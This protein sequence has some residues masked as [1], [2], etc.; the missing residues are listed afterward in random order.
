MISTLS[1]KILHPSPYFLFAFLLIAL[2]LRINAARSPNIVHPD[3]I[4]QTLEPGHRLA[5]GYGVITWE[6]REGIRSWVL[7]AFLALVMRATAWMGTG[8]TGYVWGIAIVLSMMSLT[9]VWFGFSWANHTSGMEA[10]IIAAGACAMWYGLVFFGPS[11]LT[12]VV[13]THAL[14]PGLYFG[15]YG[16]SLQERRR[17][18]LAGLF[19]GLAVSLRIQLAPA[20]IFAVVYFCYSD[21][22]RRI[23]PATIGL[24][25]PVLAFGLIDALTWSYPFQSFFRNFWLNVAAGRS[26]H[27]GTQPW[28]WYLFVLTS[29]MFPLVVLALFGFRRSPLLGWISL[30]ILVSHSMIAHK[31]IRFIYPVI[32]LIVILAALGIVEIRNDFNNALKNPVLSARVSIGLGLAFCA[33]MSFW[34]SPRFDYWAKDSGSLVAFDHLSRDPGACGVALYGVPRLWLNT[35][36]YTHLHK[37]VPIFMIPNEQLFTKE[38]PTFN[39]VVTDQADISLKGGFNL[40]SCWNGVCLYQRA[41]GCQASTESYEINAVLRESNN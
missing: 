40:V 37:S 31:E 38:M 41:G 5:Y 6:W 13:A 16:H 24:L 39:A 1:R 26:A 36:G 12:E 28:F 23:L 17:L 19:C 29:Q 35:G 32:P 15:I 10:A 18:F 14:L 4:F 7:P 20:V 25:L 27:Y 2:M 33:L 8:S 3:Q 11:A 30:I 21:W 22:R 34:L 9:T